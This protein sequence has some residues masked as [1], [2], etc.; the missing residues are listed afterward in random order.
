MAGADVDSVLKALDRDNP[1]YIL[2]DYPTRAV[3]RKPPVRIPPVVPEFFFLWAA[4]S[5]TWWVFLG[6][7]W[8]AFILPGLILS[9]VMVCVYLLDDLILP[10]RS[11]EKFARGLSVPLWRWDTKLPL[12]WDVPQSAVEAYNTEGCRD[13]AETFV[14]NMDRLVKDPVLD[15]QQRC[16]VERECVRSF[17][18]A[19]EDRKQLRQESMIDYVESWKDRVR[20]DSLP[21]A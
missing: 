10:P 15:Y 2:Q 14:H 18:K 21:P 11:M 12:D 8:E 6:H 7:N 20:F 9:G 19:F 16:D 3:V 17:H 13:L 4:I 5:T 1:R